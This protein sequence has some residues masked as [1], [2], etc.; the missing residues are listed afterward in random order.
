MMVVARKD[1]VSAMGDL[2]MS[3]ASGGEYGAGSSRGDA[4]LASRAVSASTTKSPSGL[5]AGW[6]AF[7]VVGLVAT[8]CRSAGPVTT[9]DG[10]PV[11]PA[12]ARASEPAAMES[13]EE[14]AAPLE[15]TGIDIRE[16]APGVVVEL[17]SNEPLVWT[18]FRD[19]DG[20]VVVELPNAM[21]GPGVDDLEPASGLVQSIR[22]SREA[23]GRRP[24]TRLVIA[25]RGD[26]EHNLRAD[27]NLL[28]LEL[29]PQ[30]GAGGE[31]EG[32]L[33]F[34]PIAEPEPAL[35]ADRAFED[36]ELMEPVAP[37]P[38][39]PPSPTHPPS[40]GLSMGTPDAP[41]MGPAPNGT[42]ASRL[43][44]V[45]VDSAGEMTAVEIRGDG[46]FAYSTFRLSDPPRFV[47][48]LEG[49]VNR[50]SRSAIPVSRGSVE[51]VR[52]AQF[53]P[54]PNPVARVVVDLRHER[55]PRIERTPD[56]LVLRFDEGG[57]AMAA[58]P[59]TPP[60]PTRTAQAR[61]APPPVY[62]GTEEPEDFDG[63]MVEA[64]EAA[65][66]EQQVEITNRPEPARMA[67]PPPPPPPAPIVEVER[68]VTPRPAPSDATLYG[69]EPV[70][71]ETPAGGENRDERGLVFDNR[72]MS[73]ER[74]YFGE[75][76]DMSLKDADVVETIRSF[77]QISGLSIV[78]QPQVSGRVTVELH[79][80]PWDQ[81]LEQILKIN[82]L[83]YEVAG[84]IM[85]IAP[86]PMLRAEAQERQQLAAAQ[87]LSLPLETVMTRLSYTSA[88]NLASILRRGG[89][90]SLLSQRGSVIVDARTN[91]LIISELPEYM[92]TIL[93]IIDN[94]D[95]PE[96]QVMIEA[97]IIETTK[98][99]SKELGVAWG[100]DFSAGPQTGN[101][102]G[103]EFPNTVDGSGSVNLG[104]A[105][106]NGLIQ[107]SLGNILDTFR[108][109]AV[110]NAAEEDGLVN[111]LSTPKVSTLNN[112]Q[113]TIQSGLQ[114]PIQ[115]V[116]NN[117]V[118]VQFV[119]ATLRLEV[120]PQITADG[121]VVMDIY[122]Q[123]R[124]VQQAFLVPG[125]QNAPISTKEART[126]VMVRDGG[127]AVIGG[128]YEVTTDQSQNRV[129][130]LA[131]IPILGHLFRNNDRT[132][133]NEELLIFIT[134]RVVRL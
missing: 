46:E 17:S 125:A 25:T 16:G 131:N 124:Q 130:G 64:A 100:F 60:A 109:D 120:T 98:R 111:I 29:E 52:V 36:S 75:L 20:R 10:S 5:R 86:L 118:T 39:A 83:G 2:E 58:P 73:S 28:S 38:P 19:A 122:I 59:P 4:V 76:I 42:A 74:K 44:A 101:S 107:L 43:S 15:L 81:A 40:A 110:L 104:S 26:V 84:N 90:G 11:E 41:M 97:R 37:A 119:N 50:S 82:N 95:E 105:G 133:S 31:T 80:V 24:I 22:V 121:T 30:D 91:T 8:G 71:L 128:I 62:A 67:A 134:P 69:G 89:G 61:P 48:D 117:T 112:R 35:T 6:L 13:A 79:D 56:A 108:L 132:D 93:S 49:V 45:D 7:L 103:L 63:S 68:P 66:A 55:A 99:F 27:G 65:E 123:K 34:E 126:Q 70:R 87:A 72:Q 51:R 114:I 102:T 85:R 23:G 18:S 94:L 1:E 88:T 12:E 92:D 47:V 116:A 14:P 77:A 3:F 21:P 32:A 78:V 96:P 127:T 57:M 106:R 115:T 129:P 54:F 9:G 53:K 113:A 33:T